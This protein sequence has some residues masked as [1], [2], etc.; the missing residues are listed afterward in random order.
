M[1]KEIEAEE[2]W[3]RFRCDCIWWDDDHKVCN[4]PEEDLVVCRCK[5]CPYYQPEE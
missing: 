4:C 3:K 5:E 2:R 1:E